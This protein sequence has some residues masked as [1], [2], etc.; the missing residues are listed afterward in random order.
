MLQQ[1]MTKP[2]EIIF[3][4]VPVPEI[5]DSQVLV[6]IMKIGICLPRQTPI[7]QISGDTGARGIRPDREMW[8]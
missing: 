7:Y 4:E 5:G 1:V 6:K 3:Q 8:G 2:G